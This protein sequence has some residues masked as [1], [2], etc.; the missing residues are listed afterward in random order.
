MGWTACVR[1]GQ[2]LDDKDLHLLGLCRLCLNTFLT[3]KNEDL[4]ALLDTLGQAAALVA[5]DHTVLLS[6]NRLSRMLE[7]FDHDIVGLRIGEALECKYAT[8][9][10][11][12]GE[13]E[14][15][16]HC[17]LRRLVEIARISGE[18]IGQF[19]MTMRQRSGSSQTFT[20]ASEK[21]G[22]AVLLMIETRG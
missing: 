19:P 16:L 11:C 17:G 8:H 22:E 13:S 9:E 12:C 1:C 6:N 5:R 21:A 4:S 20:F 7:K 3:T 15:C 2:H 18:K 10:R 14:V